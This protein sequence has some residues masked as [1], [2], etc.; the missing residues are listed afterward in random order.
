MASALQ[1]PRE[2]LLRAYR[3]MRTIRDFEDT[4]HDEFS[5]GGIPGFV[6]LYAARKRPASA[7]VCIS[8]T[9]TSSPRPI[10]A[11]ATASRRDAAPTR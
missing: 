5:A 1:L 2:E 7:S 9:A 8:T 11:M 4:V 10:A 6:H 3:Q